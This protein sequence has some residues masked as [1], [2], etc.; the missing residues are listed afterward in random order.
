MYTKIWAIGIGFVQILVRKW[1]QFICQQA[2]RRGFILL[3]FCCIENS[4]FQHTT[5]GKAK[6]K[7]GSKTF[8]ITTPIT[9]CYNSWEHT[10]K[11]N[12]LPNI[13]KQ[14]CIQK[15]CAT[16]HAKYKQLISQLGISKTAFW[17]IASHWAPIDPNADDVYDSSDRAKRAL[18]LL[19]NSLSRRLVSA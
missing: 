2:P 7:E 14:R 13:K 1:G 16:R 8:S 17:S 18:F 15:N 5:I 4:A 3:C 11:F 6:K 12:F 9:H 19:V 10:C